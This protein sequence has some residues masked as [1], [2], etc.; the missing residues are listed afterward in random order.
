MIKRSFFGI[1]KPVLEYNILGSA[2]SEIK[3]IPLPETVRLF[4][5]NA[6]DSL[7]SVILK[8]G[9]SVNTGQKLA[10]TR[11][12][13]IV[14]TITGT[15]KNV[16]IYIGDFGRKHSEIT[17]DVSDTE[18]KDTAFTDVADN[19]LPDAMVEYLTYLPGKPG[20]SLFTDSSRFK[21]LVISGMDDDLLVT[22]RQ[23]VLKENFNSVKK[24]IKKLKQLTNI[25]KIYMTVPERLGQEAVAAGAD[26][27]VVDSF[28]PSANPNFIVEKI[29]GSPVPAGKRIEDEG[30]C[31]I[32]ADAVASIGEAFENKQLPV[33]KI[34]TLTDKY[35]RQKLV[36]ARIGAPL[37]D[38][39]KELYVTINENDRIVIGG[40]MTGAAVYSED[41]SICPD[42]DAV[43]VQDKS[44]LPFVTDS[45]CI[46]CGECIRICPAKVPV[47]TLVRFLEAGEYEEAADN[48]DLNSCIDCGL[49]SY[50]CTA[51]IPVFH[52][53]R[54]A[55]YE[56]SR[57]EA[58]EEA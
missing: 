58:A 13:S 45:Y 50:V 42:T 53:I 32:S 2:A 11:T 36:S 25:E 15:V 30:F 17:I 29:T 54:L 38:I 26:A 49:C 35:N 16:T 7:A 20:A 44:D 55:K 56:L 57:I 5:D 48:H 10:I 28:Y 23:F 3:T 47:N 31:F 27:L 46:N 51:G 24:G 39:F 4:S 9:D 34:F 37:K 8:P 19:P 1:K 14:S 18:E 6:Y 12:D 40:P 43:I 22:T 21:C 33:N 52:Y 41:Y